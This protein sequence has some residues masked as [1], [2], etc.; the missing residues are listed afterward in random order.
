MTIRCLH[1]CIAFLPGVLCLLFS[2]NL[3]AQ[4]TSSGLIRFFKIEKAT[5]KNAIHLNWAIAAKNNDSVH[6]V[7]ER[8][9]D[10]RKFQLLEMMPPYFAGMDSNYNYTDNL[11]LSDSSFYRISCTTNGQ[12]SSY[13]VQKA[14]FFSRPKI[15]IS[16]MPNPVFNNASI[17]IQTEETGDINCMLYDLSGKTIRTYQFKKTA[18]YAQHILDMY[19]VPKGEYILNIRGTVINESKRILKQ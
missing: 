10:G 11:P 3:N 6:V 7:I 8:S 17:I 12:S 16:V 13:A 19:N 1:T 4:D 9:V 15:E 18:Y 5:N 2:L 14:N